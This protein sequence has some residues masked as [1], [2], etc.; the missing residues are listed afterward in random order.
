MGEKIKTLVGISARELVD[1]INERNVKKEEIISII[2][3]TENHQFL[4]FYMKD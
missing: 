4:C 1:K 3:D 2:Q